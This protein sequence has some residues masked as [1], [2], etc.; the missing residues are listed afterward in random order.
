MDRAWQI[1][2]KLRP[3]DPIHPTHVHMCV[4]ARFCTLYCIL[5]LPINTYYLFVCVFE[6]YIYLF[7]LY[8]FF[9]CDVIATQAVSPHLGPQRRASTGVCPPPQ[10]STPS[11]CSCKARHGSRPSPTSPFSD[12]C[13]ARRTVHQFQCDL[14]TQSLSHV[15]LCHPMDCSPPGSSVHGIL[16]ARTLEWVA[17]FSY[18]G[19]SQ[20][21]DWTYVSRVSCVDRLGSL[22]LVPLGKPHIA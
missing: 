5:H 1:K 7:A 14:R 15:W 20:P 11:C 2:L 22:P 8:F 21:R 18:R 13:P 3:W 4:A 10:P 17:M 16:Q 9:Q 6:I 19:S 12:R